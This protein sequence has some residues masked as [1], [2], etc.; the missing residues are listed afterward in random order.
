[1]SHVISTPAVFYSDH[2]SSSAVRTVWPT[3]ATEYSQR[4]YRRMQ[5]CRRP[6]QDNHKLELKIFG[7]EFKTF[8][9]CYMNTGELT[10]EESGDLSYDRALDDPS[11]QKL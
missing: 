5:K 7:A 11:A 10:L 9:I 8:K 6:S 2:F 4:S 1:M 3:Y